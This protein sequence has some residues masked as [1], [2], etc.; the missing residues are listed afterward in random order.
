VTPIDDRLET[1]RAVHAPSGGLAERPYA[2]LA[3]VAAIGLSVLLPAI[4]LARTAL[5]P[6]A[7][8]NPLISLIATACV[9]PLH[10]RHVVYGLRGERPPAAALT[11]PALAAVNVA[12]AMAVGIGWLLNFALLAVS[13]LIV[14]SWPWALALATVVVGSAAAFAGNDPLL[15]WPFVALSIVW[16]TVTL[17]VPVRLVAAVG[18]LD[19]ARRELRDRAVVRERLRIEAELRRGL[20]GALDGIVRSAARA[21]AAVTA[22]VSV[23]ATELRA[24][25]GRSRQALADARRLIV[26]FR[27]T[28]V[29]AELDAAV[30]L[31]A[32]AGVKSHVVVQDGLALDGVDARSRSIL[33]SAV[34]RAL[35]DESLDDCRIEMSRDELGELRIVVSP[36]SDATTGRLRT[37]PR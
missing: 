37:A 14:V 10:L 9:L 8:G 5:A 18:Q 35:R 2:R 28:S 3:T 20:G 34:V 32:A 16:R 1:R 17:Y 27:E 23:A 4:E 36:V 15:P 25:V 31:L 13:V 11:L 24:L 7:Y 6:G 29:A 21:G 26:E 19:G 33:R 12:A 30:A 22:D